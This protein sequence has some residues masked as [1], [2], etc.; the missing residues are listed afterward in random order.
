MRRRERIRTAVCP[1]FLNGQKQPVR[2]SGRLSP[3]L[4]DTAP[5]YDVLLS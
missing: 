2:P 3:A 1:K 5:Q 4:A